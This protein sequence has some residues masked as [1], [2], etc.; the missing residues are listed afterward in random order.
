MALANWQ[1]IDYFWHALREIWFKWLFSDTVT[2]HWYSGSALVHLRLFY[3]ANCL[4]KGK[5]LSKTII[6]SGT[7]L[8]RHWSIFIELVMDWMGSELTE[9][10]NLA[11]I[12]ASDWS[13]A[14]NPALW[15]VKRTSGKC[16][17]GVPLRSW[18]CATGAVLKLYTMKTCSPE[19]MLSLIDTR[20]VAVAQQ[21]FNW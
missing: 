2:L 9:A 18:V 3:S 8:A 15:L 21:W 17:K 6:S 19:I 14:K 7:E 16:S 20:V 12:E 4:Y 5:C 1:S 10:Q 13:R 11:E